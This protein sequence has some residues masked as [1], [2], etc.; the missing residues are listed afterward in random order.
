MSLKLSTRLSLKLSWNS[1]WN[2][3]RSHKNCPKNCP[4]L[5][6]K[7]SKKLSESRSLHLLAEPKNSKN[8]YGTIHILRQ[9][10]TGWL[11]LADCQFCWRSVLY[12]CW[13]NTLS[14]WVRKSPQL[15]WRYI[16]MMLMR[17]VKLIWNSICKSFYWKSRLILC[18][19]LSR[20]WFFQ[21]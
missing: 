9:Q 20:R 4:R 19:F 2:C 1:L 12:L 18:T 6:T 13:F 17:K 7:L 5:S 3:Q 11:G 21:C 16:W 10:S 8:R 14:G 15:C